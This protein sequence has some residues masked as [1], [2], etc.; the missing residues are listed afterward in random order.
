MQWRMHT[1]DNLVLGRPVC[2]PAVLLYVPPTQVLHRYA[3]VWQCCWGLAQ[4]LQRATFYLD[5]HQGIG[6]DFKFPCEQDDGFDCEGRPLQVAKGKSRFMDSGN[7]IYGCE[8]GRLAFEL[9]DTTSVLSR[10]LERVYDEILIDL[11]QYLHQ[12]MFAQ[13]TTNLA[14]VWWCSLSTETRN[15]VVQPLWRC[16]HLRSA[17]TLK[18]G[19][20]GPFFTATS[21]ASCQ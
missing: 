10:R 21:I 16:H 3:G 1:L 4:A 15:Q 8:L 9:M 20:F 7:R 12:M 14:L 17:E 5:C 18:N 19:P 6:G 2:Q 13:H 11:V